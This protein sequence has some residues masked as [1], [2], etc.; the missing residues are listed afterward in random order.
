M[1]IFKLILLV[2]FYITAPIFILHICK[3]YKFASRIGPVLWLYLLGILLGNCGLIPPSAHL[4]QDILISILVPIAICMMLF[5]MNFQKW[6]IRLALK[7]LLTGIAAIVITTII[8]FYLF[9]PHIEG[10][11]ISN[12][13]LYKIPGLLTGVYTGG[14]PNLAALKLMLNVPN[15]IYIIIHSYDMLIGLFYLTFILSIGI[16]IFRFFLPSSILTEKP[17]IDNNN[18]E[19]V[20][21]D[22]F[23][24]QYRKSLLKSFGLSFIIFIFSGVISLLFPKSQQMTVIILSLT[25]LGIIASFS[26]KIQAWEKSYDA[27]MY[28]ILIFSLV[29]ASMA[30]LSHLELNNSLWLL[31]YIAFA[32][33]GSLVVQTI[34]S[35]IF[36][37]DSDTMM[38]ASVALINSPPF[39]PLM[40]T[41]LKNKQVLVTGL[42][43]GI[44]GYGAGNYLGFLVTELLRW[45]D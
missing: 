11:F 4:L 42:T 12:E 32:V 8:G 33:F 2:I 24:K 14:T 25:T 28:L 40:V 45:I 18:Q 13:E 22:I 9:R 31:F 17:E 21:S 7:S 15:E 1:E 10:A 5:S 29:V 39:V 30:N 26:K 36:R 3:R 38:V 16:R 44:I 27:G 34:L 35:R 43:I 41:A 37:I 23:K 6:S 20:S 19:M